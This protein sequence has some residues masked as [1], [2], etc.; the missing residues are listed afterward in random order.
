MNKE[1]DNLNATAP[2]S[3]FKSEY[4]IE[5]HDKEKIIK[6]IELSLNQ[7]Q[8][9]D[10]II[11]YPYQRQN[12]KRAPSKKSRGSIYRGVSRNGKMW[13]VQIGNV[14]QKRYMGTS[15]SEEAAARIYDANSILTNGMKAKTNFPYTKRDLQDILYAYYSGRE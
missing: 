3:K 4:I 6:E 8:D 1:G 11:I 14:A 9:I 2:P 12:A 5:S 13:Q 7:I 15:E 10:S